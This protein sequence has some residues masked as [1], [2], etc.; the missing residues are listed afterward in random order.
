MTSS[1]DP[2]SQNAPL[3]LYE[4]KYMRFS[5]KQNKMNSIPLYL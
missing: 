1:L 2:I 5:K 4:K 3:M